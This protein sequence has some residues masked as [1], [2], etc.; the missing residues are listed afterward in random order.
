MSRPERE[1]TLNPTALAVGSSIQQRSPASRLENSS[2]SRRRAVSF[3]AS[4]CRYPPTA[5]SSCPLSNSSFKLRVSVTLQ[6]GQTAGDLCPP[7]G[8]T[9][10]T[11]VTCS[12]S[13]GDGPR[14]DDRTRSRYSTQSRAGAVDNHPPKPFGGHAFGDSRAKTGNQQMTRIPGDRRRIDARVTDTGGGERRL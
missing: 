1:S 6:R 14:S 10:A 13:N 4:S 3:P 9:Q 5:V 7:T 2:N 12:A 8:M 11:V